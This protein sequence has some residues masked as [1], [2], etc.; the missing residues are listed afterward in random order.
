MTDENCFWLDDQPIAFQ[1]GQ[2]IMQ[3]ALAAGMYIPHLCFHDGLTPHGSC[4]L[5]IVYA[6]DKIRAAC[7]TRNC[8]GCG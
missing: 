6:D 4:R 8:S 5:C 7:A 1:P 3:A 2:T